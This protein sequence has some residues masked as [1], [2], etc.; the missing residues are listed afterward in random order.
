MDFWEKPDNVHVLGPAPKGTNEKDR[1]DSSSL[2]LARCSPTSFVPSM[3]ELL[4]P[5]SLLSDKEG[6]EEETGEPG[7]GGA[8]TGL[9][10]DGMTQPSNLEGRKDNASSPNTRVEPATNFCVIKT[11][12]PAR[13]LKPP[14]TQSLKQEKKC[15]QLKEGR[16]SSG[17]PWHTFLRTGA[18]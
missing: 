16:A 9:D 8:P 14:N 12:C 1:K 5:T 18:Q 15:I 4:P 13:T 10:W 6:P 7:R 11:C 17:R 2:D 3:E